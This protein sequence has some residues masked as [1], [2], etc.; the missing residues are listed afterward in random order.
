MKKQLWVTVLAGLV[1][2]LATGCAMSGGAN[3]NQKTVGN[4]PGGVQLGLGDIA[5]AP[6][7]DYVVFKQGKTLAVGFSG[8]GEIAEL[9]VK[10]P[11]RLA[12]SN[13]RPVIYVGSASDGENGIVAIDVKQGSVLWHA[14]V[15]DASTENLQL[16]VS[17][18]DRY[19]V[20]GSPRLVETLDGAN[21]ALVGSRIL[22]RSLVDLKILGD[23]ARALVVEEHT[24]N[25]VPNT[26]VTVIRLDTHAATRMNVPNCSGTVAVSKDGSR[27]FLAPTTCQKQADEVK[28]PV[29]VIDLAVDAEKFVK[30][31][32]GFGPVAI[33]PDGTLAVA[34]F[35][36]S[37]PDRALFDDPSMMPSD[38]AARYYL[39]LIDPATLSY[40]FAPVGFELPRYAITPDGNIL[41][42][43]SHYETVVTVRLFDLPTRTFRNVNAPTGFVLDNF[44]LS[45]DSR[46]AYVLYYLSL[47]D[48]DIPQASTSSID[49]GFFP[50][51]INISA[52]DK[53]L[54]LR[55]NDHDICIFEIET[56][57]CRGSFIATT[58]E[59][60]GTTM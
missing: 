56:R 11:T 45:S 2:G 15:K 21:G 3:P 27:A 60:G 7:G 6:V 19:V 24:F 39:M 41:L 38:I 36:A 16:V 1:I 57:Q 40:E 33:T 30:N 10:N 22:D 59:D 42:V 17:D 28:D 29:S 9:P 14:Q 31:L 43:D 18:N 4:Q 53:L 46:H 13:L 32:P 48:L 5:V 47:Y 37:N 54:F 23:N 55:K 12:F 51:N 44:V 50:L 25:T 34:F 26:L 58:T 52:D 35:D 8:T 49:L 20:A